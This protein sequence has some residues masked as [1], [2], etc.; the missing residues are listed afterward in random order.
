M[1]CKMIK[2]ILRAYIGESVQNTSND[3][4]SRDAAIVPR[5]VVDFH[6][7]LT[8]YGPNSFFRRFSGHNLR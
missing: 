2:K 3:F 4:E 1:N 6:Y 5:T 8:L 7:F